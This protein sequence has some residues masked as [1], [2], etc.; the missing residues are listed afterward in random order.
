M[1]PC[2]TTRSTIRLLLA[3]V[4]GLPLV[5]ATL[6][7]VANLLAAMGDEGASAVVGHVNTAVGVAWLL[8]LVGLVVALAVRALDDTNE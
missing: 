3:F 4:L 5:Q 6:L 8:T 1:T 2:C 7:W